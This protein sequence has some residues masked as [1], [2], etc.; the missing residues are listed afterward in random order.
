M[1]LDQMVTF[2]I[3]FG[4]LFKTLRKYSV[5]TLSVGPTASHFL[6]ASGSLGTDASGP[7]CPIS[8]HWA[9]PLK[10]LLSHPLHRKDKQLHKF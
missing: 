3:D 9:G 1:H 10:F 5:G 8:F 7:M 6:V 2:I 4:F